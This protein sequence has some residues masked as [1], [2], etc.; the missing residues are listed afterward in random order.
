MQFNIILCVG[1]QNC[2]RIRK[3]CSYRAEL[4]CGFH[5]KA[6]DFIANVVGLDLISSALKHLFVIP[7]SVCNGPG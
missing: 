1:L 3:Y 6:S 7:I 4:S 5:D 2:L